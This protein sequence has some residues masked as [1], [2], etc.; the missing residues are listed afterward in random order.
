MIQITRIT[1]LS[2]VYSNTCFNNKYKRLSDDFCSLFTVQLVTWENIND[3]PTFNCLN[4]GTKWTTRLCAMPA[5]ISYIPYYTFKCMMHMVAAVGCNTAHLHATYSPSNTSQAQRRFKWLQL[6]CCESQY[7]Y[8]RVSF[9]WTEDCLHFSAWP[10]WN[11][12]A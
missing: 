12:K 10:A 1:K 6:T 7:Y 3:L 8:E 5:N 2:A 4:K 9:V 11:W